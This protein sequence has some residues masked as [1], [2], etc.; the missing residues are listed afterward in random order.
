MGFEQSSCSVQTGLFLFKD[1]TPKWTYLC[2]CLGCGFYITSV[3][4]QEAGF[5]PIGREHRAGMKL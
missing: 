1:Q 3:M 5:V 4:G 2:V